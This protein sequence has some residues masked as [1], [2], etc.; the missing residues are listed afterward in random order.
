MES[1]DQHP[2]DVAMSP[3]DMAAVALVATICGSTRVRLPA[4]V[5]GGH[6]LVGLEPA[7]LV[8]ILGISRSAAQRL[9]AA[10]DLHRHLLGVGV[11]VRPICRDPES[12]A[13]VLRPLVQVEQER[14]WCLPLDARCRLIGMP[15]EIYRGDVDA[16]DAGVRAVCRSAL[17]AGGTQMVVAHNHPS[18]DP[19]PSAADAAVTARLAA[20]SRVA[21]VP[22]LDHL[23][24]VRDG[25]WTSLRRQRPDLFT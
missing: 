16:T 3:D 12:I 21:D 24:V 25:R 22:L 19:E 1:A 7:Q 8:V 10:L 13:A 6:G 14:L 2:M 9:R 4:W 5:E 11:P 23:V 17:R 15:M 20:A 18:G